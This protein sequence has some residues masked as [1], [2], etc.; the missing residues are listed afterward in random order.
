MNGVAGFL[1]ANDVGVYLIRSQSPAT[2]GKLDAVGGPGSDKHSA[3]KLCRGFATR[4][5]LYDGFWYDTNMDMPDGRRICISLARN[6]IPG[7]GTEIVEGPMSVD[8]LEKMEQ[9]GMLLPG[10]LDAVRVCL[11]D[12]SKVKLLDKTREEAVRLA[13]KEKMQ[14]NEELN[15]SPSDP[16]EVSDFD[17][18]VVKALENRKKIIR[19]RKKP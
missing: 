18:K 1:F 2:M 11:G 15:F 7:C 3:G 8:F 14:G 16:K 19:I 12:F 5:I 9:V 4:Q 13:D 17:Y 6:H 10:I